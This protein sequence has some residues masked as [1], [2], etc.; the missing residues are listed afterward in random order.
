M[1]KLL[2][3]IAIMSAFAASA[4]AQA[5]QVGV[6]QWKLVRLN[7][8][9]IPDT[10][11]AYLELNADETRFTGNAGCN[12]MFGAVGI[13]RNRIDFSRIGTTKMAC[14]DRRTQRLESDFIRNLENIGSIRASG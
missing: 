2:V 1:K 14:T 5:G 8:V 6:R 13:R 11:R 7:G 9:H 4:L 3:L 10:S 12:R